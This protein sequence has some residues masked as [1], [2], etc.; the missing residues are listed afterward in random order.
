MFKWIYIVGI[1][2]GIVAL[3][4]LIIAELYIGF[5]NPNINN[6]NIFIRAITFNFTK[7]G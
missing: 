6:L 5:V 3:L 7:G 1:I 2:I 4:Y